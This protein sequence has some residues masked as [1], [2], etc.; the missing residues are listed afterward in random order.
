MAAFIA[1]FVPIG[2]RHELVGSRTDVH[3]LLV[4]CTRG[5]AEMEEDRD[6]VSN[7]AVSVQLCGVGFDALF[8][9]H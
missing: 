9:C 8:S 1:V 2:S 7:R 4:V 3:V 6:G 5:A